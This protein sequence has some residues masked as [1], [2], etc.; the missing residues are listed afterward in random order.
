MYCTITTFLVCACCLY[1][2][3]MN[4]I[5]EDVRETAEHHRWNVYL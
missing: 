3:D 5:D 1:T 4:E 2:E